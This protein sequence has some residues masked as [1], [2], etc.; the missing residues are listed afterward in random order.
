MEV[1]AGAAYIAQYMNVEYGYAYELARRLIEWASNCFNSGETP[2]AHATV[3][4]PSDITIQTTII[5]L[6]T[7]EAV[8]QAYVS[9]W[10]LGSAVFDARGIPT[11]LRGIPFG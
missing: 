6:G 1:Q 10:P 2:I 9:Q 5:P 8:L 7:Y 11:Q 3:S 4:V